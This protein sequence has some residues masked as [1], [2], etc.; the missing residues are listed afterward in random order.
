V[1]D[2]R[3]QKG[4]IILK[5]RNLAIPALLAAAA[6][7]VT[8][9][10]ATA[11]SVLRIVPHAD[12]QMLDPM[13]ATADI[14]KLHGFMIYDTL[15]ALDADF[16]P[17]PQ[18]VD[19][20]TLSDDGL[21]YR[22]TLRDGM[23][24]HDGEPVRAE[25]AVASL[26]RW[27]ARDAAGQLMA[28]QLAEMRVVD[29]LTFEL[30]FTQPYGILLESLS[31]LAANIPFIMPKRVADTDAFTEI[32]DYTGSGPFKF[33]QAE[34]VPGSK[35]VYEKF[36]D[37]L[38][39]SEPASGMAGGKVVNVDRAEWLIISDQQT[40]LSAMMSGEIDIW[41]N[42]S[43]DLL[44]VIEAVG[45]I[46]TLVVNETGTQ[47]ATFLNQVI[48]PFDNVKARQAMFW[49]A[50]QE[51]YL[52]AVNGN[53]EFYQTCASFFICGTPME[54]DAGLESLK[55]PDP[56]KA[57]ALFEEAGWDFSKPIVVLDPTDNSIAHPLTVVTVQAMRDIGLN[58]DV[59]AM[60]W[61]TL[62]SRRTSKEPV[63]NGGWNLVH[64]FMGGQVVST[65][66][67]SIAFSGACDKGVFGWPCDQT[68]EDLRLKWAL[69][70]GLDAQKDVAAEYSLR[71]FE[72][73]HHIPLGQWNTYL[74]YG[75]KVSDVLVTQDVPVFWNLTKVD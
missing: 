41:E 11:D 37:Y 7:S 54:T 66:V 17:Q 40:A 68:L 60:D 63:E 22:F 19:T 72:V 5:L 67:W 6:F 55:G 1:T 49:L 18:M 46:K 8:A 70:Q 4:R 35:V 61:A 28:R 39:R 69:A 20:M 50:D 64:S 74:A 34:W 48:P 44:P 38:P 14:I 52:Q 30:E 56:A 24:W 42:P 65:P 47:G 2:I 16:V 53:P 45:N 23:T 51:A 36:A 29:N 27:Q 9:P 59:Q 75:D 33:V 26:K 32:T 31:K 62:L 10:A 73:G 12:L 21:I 25:D 13:G 43:L 71:A 15:Y 3:K 58:V 57:K